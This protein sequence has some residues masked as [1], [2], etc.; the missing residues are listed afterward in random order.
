MGG[1]KKKKKMMMNR[2]DRERVRK[3][4][5]SPI[6]RK[7]Y[8]D[9]D[10]LRREELRPVRL[11]LELLKPE[12]GMI[13]QQVVSTIVCFGSTRIKPRREAKKI[14]REAERELAAKPRSRSAKHKV[15][16]AKRLLAKS[17]YYEEA[18]R[19]SRLVSASCQR[20][21]KRSFVVTTGG[22]P[23]IMEAA[24]RGAFEV[25]AKTAGLGISLP[26]EQEPNPFVSKEL[27][28]QFHYF[29]IRK[30]HFMLR[31]KAVVVFPGGYGTMDELFEAL[32]LVQTGKEP[33]IP[34]ILVGE[35]FWK[36][37]INIPFLV[38]EGTIAPR[39]AKLVTYVET[40]EEA[41][42]TIRRFYKMDR[43][44]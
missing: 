41:W 15:D 40:A 36:S 35:E 28:F 9:L 23:G 2:P 1:K 14:L 26:F 31:A 21:G 22:G 10:F 34:I 24:N 12:M 19:F 39:D 38:K 33:H 4:K 7:A 13:E 30:L 3:L 18:R 29:A 25:G 43:E 16:A 6:Y 44:T 5:D 32:C 20:D 11:Q 37:A 42:D 8:Q 27:N 17:H